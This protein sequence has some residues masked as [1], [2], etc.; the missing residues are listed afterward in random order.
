MKGD[1]M[2]TK[3]SEDEQ[4]KTV[5]GAVLEAALPHVVFDGWSNAALAR[6][7]EDAGVNPAVAR[8]A[9]PRGGLD[10]AL[11]YHYDRDAR[12]ADELATAALG[13]LR[14]RDKMAFAIYRRLELVAREKEQV[15]RAASLLSLPNHAPDAARAIWNTADTIWDALGDQS[16][17]YNWYTKRAT[18]SAVYSSSVLYW[19][20]DQSADGSATRDFIARRIDNVMQFE[21]FKSRVRK[22][23][24]A[25]S[26]LR[27]PRRMLDRV[28]APVDTAPP[29]LPGSVARET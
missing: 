14:F 11:A 12:L 27:G 25:S 15:R 3:Q 20:G 13:G 6:G 2:R 1:E 17:D 23:P 28:R 10:L 9:F 7:V 21:E 4:V 18:L 29:D 5:R 8:V 26:L 22:N 24:F 19:L 16:R